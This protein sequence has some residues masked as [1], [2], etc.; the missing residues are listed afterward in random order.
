M[1]LIFEAV[2]VRVVQERK[3]HDHRETLTLVVGGALLSP[4]IIIETSRGLDAVERAFRLVLRGVIT[5]VV[6]VLLL[7]VEYDLFE[8][9]ELLLLLRVNR[10]IAR[11]SLSWCHP[12]LYLIKVG[13]VPEDHLPSQFLDYQLAYC[14]SE[15]NTILVDIVLNAQLIE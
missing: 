1:V 4:R 15:A 3:P 2:Y 12:R 5:H 6:V 8:V 11:F 13:V 7:L 10:G 14:Q 9:C